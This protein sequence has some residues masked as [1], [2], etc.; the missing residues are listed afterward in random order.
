MPNSPIN[1]TVNVDATCALNTVTEG[2]TSGA[3]KLF[4]FFLLNVKLLLNLKHL[5]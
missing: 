2:I 5:T 4:D 1:A 3:A